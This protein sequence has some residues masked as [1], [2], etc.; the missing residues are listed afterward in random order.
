MVLMVKDNVVGKRIAYL[1]SKRGFSQVELAKKL[2]VSPSTIAMWETGDR[3][4]KSSTLVKLA[5]FFDTTTEFLTGRTDDPSPSDPLKKSKNLA[6]YGGGENLTEEE[7]EVARI[8]I[9]AYR[10]GKEK[11]NKKSDE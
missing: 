3:E 4:I 1:R 5:D 2:N 6:F 10:R 7:L 11:Q 8:A 9:E